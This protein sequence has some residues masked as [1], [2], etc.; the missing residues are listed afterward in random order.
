MF[1]INS[2]LGLSFPV[3]DLN[4]INDGYKKSYRLRCIHNSTPHCLN[5]DNNDMMTTQ[6]K[7]A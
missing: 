3:N 7:S 5:N 2:D 6:V 1:V 4:Q